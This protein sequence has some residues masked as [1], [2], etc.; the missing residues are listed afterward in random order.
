MKKGKLI[1][2]ILC[3][4]VV[5]A[6]STNFISAGSVPPATNTSIFKTTSKL[7][8]TKIGN[9]NKKTFFEKYLTGSWTNAKQYSWSETNTSSWQLSGGGSMKIKEAIGLN[10]GL[11]YG[12]S[13]SY[14]IN[15]FIESN[16]KKLSRLGFFV[17]KNCGSAFA[18][19]VDATYLGFFKFHQSVKKYTMDYKEPT[20]S[21]YLIS[22]YQGQST[23]NIAYWI[24]RNAKKGKIDKT[25]T[26]AVEI[27]KPKKK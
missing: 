15:T 10:L 27:K 13:Y 23:K 24:D 19:K 12:Q 2:V 4:A 14:G 18:K 21:S 17:T 8:T 25:N 3:I 9:E 5:G 11:A 16:S 6:L 20:D 1:S 22:V 7:T 26:Y